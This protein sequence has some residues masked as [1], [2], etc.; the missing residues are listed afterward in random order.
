MEGGGSGNDRH[1]FCK[2]IPHV[3][4]NK[5]VWLISLG[6]L[7]YLGGTEGMCGYLPLYLREFKEWLPD[8]ADGALAVFIGISTLGAIHISLFS[9][10]LGRRKLIILFIST[11]TIIGL[12]LLSIADGIIRWVI[13]VLIGI[14]RDGLVAL[15]TAST[16]DSKGIGVL[17]TGTA[18][19][20]ARQSLE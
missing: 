4:R 13:I 1:D 18:M 8:S 5:N 20:L 16:I 19:G 6:M 15:V 7:G 9:D 3:L 12:G 10:R 14:R 17:Y 11:I 2:A